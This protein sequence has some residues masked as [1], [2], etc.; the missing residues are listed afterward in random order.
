MSPDP[1]GEGLQGRRWGGGA[2]GEWGEASGGTAGLGPSVRWGPASRWG[3]GVACGCGKGAR[4][5]DPDGAECKLITAGKMRA[6]RKTRFL[7]L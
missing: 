5:L 6:V 7:H 3:R 4:A 1:A 2:E